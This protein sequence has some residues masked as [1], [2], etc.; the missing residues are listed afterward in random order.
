MSPMLALKKR[1]ESEIV[2]LAERMEA[3]EGAQI[4]RLF[5]QER[6]MV[7]RHE[8]EWRA[9]RIA[10]YGLSAVDLSQLERT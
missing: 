8:R 4:D 6:A 2:K 1:Q 3:A 10:T 7:A 9:T 5:A